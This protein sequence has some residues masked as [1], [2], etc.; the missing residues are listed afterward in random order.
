MNPISTTNFK[1]AIGNLPIKVS[2]DDDMLFSFRN[3]VMTNRS[4]KESESNQIPEYITS[5]YGEISYLLT[6][7]EDNV[8]QFFNEFKMW[9]DEL[10]NETEETTSNIDRSVE[11]YIKWESSEEDIEDEQNSL[12]TL[13][14]IEDNCNEIDRQF[15]EDV[16]EEQFNERTKQEKYN[17]IKVFKILY[18]NI[19]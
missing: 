9:V 14:D 10:D 12:I 13:L 2:R 5:R 6:N 17:G 4:I 16:D 18:H 8:T 19:F 15:E 7:L 1:F 11:K 3:Q